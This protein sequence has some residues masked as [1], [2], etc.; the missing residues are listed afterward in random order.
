MGYSLYLQYLV[1]KWRKRCKK[2][3]HKCSFNIYPNIYPDIYIYTYL[4]ICMSLNIK[5]P[6]THRLYYM[7]L[8]RAHWM[9]CLYVL[10]LIIIW[11]EAICIW[12]RFLLVVNHMSLLGW[13]E[14]RHG[15]EP[16]ES[17]WVSGTFWM[18]NHWSLLGYCIIKRLT[19]WGYLGGA[20]W[21]VTTVNH[22]K[23]S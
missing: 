6:L 2:I 16:F 22:F 1:V 18:V 4:N 7:K 13:V 20:P 15:G 3:A 14:H 10:L 5:Y 11:D 23:V 19:V 9:L 12:N 8:H 21:M 17:T